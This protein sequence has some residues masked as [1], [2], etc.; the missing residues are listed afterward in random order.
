[1]ISA[2]YK[3][4]DAPRAMRDLAARKTHG[5]VVLVPDDLPG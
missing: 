2:T 4:S 1:V 5:K 3:L